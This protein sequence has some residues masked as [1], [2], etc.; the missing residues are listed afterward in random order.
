MYPTRS[1]G[2][3]LGEFFSRPIQITR[4]PPCR[5]CYTSCRPTPRAPSRP[6]LPL[7]ALRPDWLHEMH[8]IKH[9]GE[10][11]SASSPGAG[12]MGGGGFPRSR[13]A[14]FRRGWDGYG[15]FESA[16]GRSPR[17][18]EELHEWLERRGGPIVSMRPRR[19]SVGRGSVRFLQKKQTRYAQPEPFC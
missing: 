4:S 6:A 11:G 19:R 17:S 8:E 16:C 10:R 7:P 15:A 14:A 12:L 13:Q 9:D 5:L 1:F 18:N 2:D 3:I